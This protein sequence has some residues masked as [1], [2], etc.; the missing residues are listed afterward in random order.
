AEEVARVAT[1]DAQSPIPAPATSQRRVVAEP[2]FSGE[3]F[4][5]RS[6]GPGPLRR[7]EIRQATFRRMAELI[8]GTVT[9]LVVHPVAAGWRVLVL[10]RATDTRCPGTWE[11]VHGRIE[12]GEQ[13]EDAAVREVKEETGLTIQ[14]LYNVM[15]YPFYLHQ[16]HVVEVSVVFAAFVAE[17]HVLTLGPEHDHFEWLSAEDARDRFHWPRER[18]ALS[19]VLQLLGG[20]DAGPAEDVL[21]VR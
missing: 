4:A 18:E 17:S 5:L 7:V 21:R 1:P 9:V 3:A 14:R 15:A 6:D 2:P 8:V 19:S 20:G 16:Q 13:P 10:R 12:S 11:A